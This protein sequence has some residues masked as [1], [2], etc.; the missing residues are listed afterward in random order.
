MHYIAAR[1]QPTGM[2]RMSWSQG[3]A[4]LGL[5]LAV[6]ASLSLAIGPVGWR[7]GWWHYRFAFA[8]LM[9]ASAI[10]ALGAILVALGSILFGRSA[11]GTAG[12]AV[13]ALALVMGIVLLYI[14][15]HYD[16]LRKTV[17]RIHDITTDTERPPEFSTVL[18]ARAAE[19]AAT[20]VYEGPELARQQKA[21][22]P[23]IAPFRM[24][25]AVGAAFQ[26]ALEVARAM[27]GWTVIAADPATGRIEASQTSR[28]FRFTDDIV[29]RVTADGSGSR[30]DMRSLS[31]Q[32][33][34]D[35]G[36]NAARIGAYM[37]ALKRR[38]G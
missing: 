11:I 35:F 19:N 27:P 9:T 28:W 32:G 13:G 23:E 8:W 38:A 16:R 15:W 18:P 10:L 17:P 12:G 33:R 7:M 20:A 26:H 4:W 1:G 14:P 30:I 22:Y 34:S 37:G 31:R 29:I 3:G 6:L 24:P 36:V 5:S 21:A 2:S 25:A